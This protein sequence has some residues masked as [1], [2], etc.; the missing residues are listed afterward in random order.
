MT[1]ADNVR[2]LIAAGESLTVEFKSR[3]EP[4]RFSEDKLSATVACM[5][6]G[7][8]G[9]LLIG[10]EDDGTITGCAPW[11]RKTGATDP[12]RLEALI[13][14]RT[15]PPVACQ[16][17]VIT[18]DGH[19][20]VQVT[21]P[22]SPSPV[23][24]SNGLYQ[25][26]TMRI[27][28]GPECVAMDP[29][30][31]F[32]RYNSVN[33][34]DWSTLD[35]VG[36]TLQD[37]DTREF[38]RFRAMIRAS[39]GDDLLADLPD[40]DI[41]RALRFYDNGPDPV[42]L[43]AVLLFGT[44]SSVARWIPN[45]EIIFQVMD[46]NAVSVNHRTT[47][48]LFAAVEDV[49]A[50]LDVYRTEDEITLG[51]VRVA[52]PNLPERVSREA[53]AN[54]LIHRD[55][56]ALGPV[57]ILLERERLSVTSP[58]GLPRGV[59]LETII[60]DSVPRSPALADAFKRAG[61][62]DRA[63]RGVRLMYQSLLRS[64][65]GEPDYTSTTDEQVVVEIPTADTDREFARFV[66]TWQRDHGD[67]DVRQLRVLHCLHADGRASSEDLAALLGEKPTRL[68]R[69][70]H[71]LTDLSLVEALGRGATR[72][73]RLGSAFFDSV[74]RRSDFIRSQDLDDV[75]A[76]QLILAYATEY[77]SVT[78]A[79]AAET[80]GL[81]G[82]AVYRLLKELTNSGELQKHGT[83]RN[84]YYTLPER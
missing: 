27:N 4:G 42:K 75:R 24:T 69:T 65:H 18:V 20:I 49:T 11:D 82:T 43:G 48:P 64:G 14:H 74:G 77:G 10:V 35:A 44:R 53:V 70:V 2:S 25:R 47:S 16:V 72:E 37:L 1:S 23:A 8:G 80:C 31:L 57:K 52:L 63:G 33:A 22:A 56:T 55:Y 3:R 30:Y 12:A 84:T 46:G 71:R 79:Q 13:Q 59:T 67:L 81:T 73:Y 60:E 38:D 34:R 19:D 51:M 40:E 78:R 21:V 68:R 66:A 62:V 39:G 17:E 9:Q 61:I 50:R 26:R 83:T 29:S 15:V 54:A 36:A 6:N 41:L 76:R 28:G 7:E 58:G 5:A 45:H 32:S